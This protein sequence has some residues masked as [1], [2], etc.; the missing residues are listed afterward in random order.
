M[1]RGDRM[2]KRDAMTM[3]TITHGKYRTRDGGEAIVLAVL[4]VTYY[5]VIGYRI[6]Q[7]EDYNYA[8]LCK[9]ERDG[10]MYITIEDDDDL[11]E[12]IE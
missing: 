5:P 9:W 12:R 8:S 2:Q 10:R 11:M 6:V 1:L 4:D 7:E 3:D